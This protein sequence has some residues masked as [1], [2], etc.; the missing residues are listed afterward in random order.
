MSD[1]FQNSDKDEKRK[2]YFMIAATVLVV[3][4]VIVVVVILFV[5]KKKNNVVAESV[6]QQTT[7][8][9]ETLKLSQSTTEATESTTST[10]SVVK[11]TS[12]AEYEKIFDDIDD[13]VTA[14]DTTNLRSSY[15][16]NADVVGSISYGDYLQRTGYNDNGWSRLVYEGQIVY[17]K[18]QLLLKEGESP[19][20]IASWPDEFGMTWQDVNEQV[21]AKDETNLRTAPS[22]D[23]DS[24]VY[25]VLKKGTY[26]T[27]VGLGDKGWS[28][29][30][31]DGQILYAVTSY[32]TK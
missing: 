18:T 21:T 26:V 3:I 4:A 7:S 23:T 2:I 29:I 31:Y 32:L 16:D 6:T 5:P 10:S 24:S 20:T 9:V 30:S 13:Y 27:R 19:A 14:K 8:E 11:D 22:Q 25:T 17:A 1:L 28:K 15:Y 12:S